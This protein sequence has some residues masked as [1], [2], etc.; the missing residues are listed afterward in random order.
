VLRK[1]EKIDRQR[2]RRKTKRS[3]EDREKG[4]INRGFIKT[5]RKDK[6]K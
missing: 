3:D 1:T 4:V 6:D 2:E 5:E